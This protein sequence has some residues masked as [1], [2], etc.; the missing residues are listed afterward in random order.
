MA[1]SDAAPEAVFVFFMLVPEDDEVEEVLAAGAEAGA[2]A[3]VA[4]AAAGGAAELLAGA[5]MS[6]AAFLPLRLFF[7]ELAD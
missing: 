2:D 1:G 7:E 4:G 6:L 5:L 3:L